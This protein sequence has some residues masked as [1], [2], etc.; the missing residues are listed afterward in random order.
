MANIS[1]ESITIRPA[2]PQDATELSALIARTFSETFGPHTPPDDL[3]VHVASTYTPELQAAEIVDP[4]GNI[5]VVET[6][7]PHG[8]SSLI[9]YA[10]LFRSPAPAVITGPTPLELK[11][12]YVDFSWHGRGIAQM[13]MTEVLRTA[14]A[15]GARTL[16]LGVWEGNA[17]AIAFYRKYGFLRVG[18]HLFPVGSD[19][20]IDWLLVRSLDATLGMP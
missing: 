4:A 5:L 15:Q 14:M 10:H 6:T 7:A 12:F 1:T 17:R 8:N 18:E 3:A 13:L 19:P 11:R 9:G 16:W 20:Q 2:R